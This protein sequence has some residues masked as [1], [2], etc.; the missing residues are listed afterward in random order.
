MKLIT[1]VNKLYN[2]EYVPSIIK[3]GEERFIFQRGNY[4]DSEGKSLFTRINIPLDL[5]LEVEPIGILVES[6]TKEVD[7]L[8]DRIK[9]LENQIE[10]LKGS[11]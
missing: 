8:K 7:L 10:Y 4:W 9:I 6:I 1:I 2:K 5:S 11:E 3:I